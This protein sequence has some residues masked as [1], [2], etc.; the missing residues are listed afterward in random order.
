M[1]GDVVVTGDVPPM[2]VTPGSARGSRLIEAL[3]MP[4]EDVATDL[5]W[6]GTRGVAVGPMHPEDVGVTLTREERLT[7][8]RMADL[9]GQYYTR[10]NNGGQDYSTAGRN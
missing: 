8:A 6:T 2:W 5:A 3:N 10:W 1:M 4:A 7:L 9:G